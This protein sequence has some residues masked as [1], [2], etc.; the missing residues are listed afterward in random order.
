VEDDVA[1]VADVAGVA[2]VADVA[3]VVDVVDVGVVGK[4]SGTVGGGVGDNV[5]VDV[6]SLLFVSKSEILSSTPTTRDRNSFV[7]ERSV[8]NN[9]W[10]S[11]VETVS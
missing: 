3:D 10:A 4:G 2:D 9:F 7:S 8:A 1:D 11:S 6:P 5:V